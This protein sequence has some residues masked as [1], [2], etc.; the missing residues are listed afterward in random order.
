MRSTITLLGG[1]SLLFLVYCPANAWAAAPAGSPSALPNK[2][3]TLSSELTAKNPYG[4]SADGRDT[5]SG[6]QSGLKKA[7]RKTISDPGPGQT[8]P[9]A[10]K[11][12]IE[13]GS[14]P[15]PE[16]AAHQLREGLK[17]TGG[18]L[19]GAGLL[20]GVGIYAWRHRSRRSRPRSNPIIRVLMFPTA[21]SVPPEPPVPEALPQPD[22]TARQKMRSAA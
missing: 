9:P 6:L 12:L 19:A 16:A 13:K 17:G 14:T 1:G 18:I 3:I 10:G 2:G 5:T 20:T 11:F 8:I 21:Y 22:M 15:A 7:T 4:S